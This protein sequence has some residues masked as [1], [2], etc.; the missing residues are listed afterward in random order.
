MDS[1]G[2]RNIVVREQITLG[3]RGGRYYSAIGEALF[4]GITRAHRR[5]LDSARRELRGKFRTVC[6]EPVLRREVVAAVAYGELYAAAS[7]GRTP[8]EFARH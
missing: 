5:R 7:R 4:L 8:A 3:C 1:V 6:G 2:L